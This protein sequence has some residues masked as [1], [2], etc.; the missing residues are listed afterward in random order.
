MQEQEKKEPTLEENFSE[1]EQVI[2]NLENRE[3]SLEDSFK[4]YQKGMQLIKSCSG[5]IDRVEKKML[6]ISENGE[7]SEF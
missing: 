5:T 2:R 7:Y 4:E 1:L 3:I 6:K